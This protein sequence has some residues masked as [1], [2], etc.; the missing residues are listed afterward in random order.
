MFRRAV[1]AV[2]ALLC[3]QAGVAEAEEPVTVFAAA[4]TTEAMSAVIEAYEAEGHGPVRA[5]FAASSILA[6]QL[7][8]GAPGEVYLSANTAWMDWLE[9]RGGA[10]AES[11]AD[12]LSNALVLVIPSGAPGPK[13]LTD[14][15]A[16]LG[17]RRLAMGDPTHVPAGRYA[18][19]ALEH[20]GLWGDLRGKTAF[21]SDVR[22][23]LALVA[24]GEAAAGVV[25][26]TDARV[27]DAVR[28]AERFPSDSHPPISYP[29]AL[30]DG[31]DRPAARAFYK[32]LRSSKAAEIFRSH[33]FRTVRPEPAS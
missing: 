30:V 10:A 15:P 21:G 24:R 4:S 32:F 11:R 12:L 19:A 7:A 14:L 20:L 26:S 22:V 5:S 31:R 27:S 16:Y 28:I 29:L 25:Y 6:K 23:A 2:F 9:E 3:V 33:G 8:A 13:L 1:A 17:D 18:K